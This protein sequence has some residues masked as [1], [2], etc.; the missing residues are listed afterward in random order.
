MPPLEISR[1]YLNLQQKAGNPALLFAVSRS[2]P[3]EANTTPNSLLIWHIVC[4][5][6]GVI[7][8]SLWSLLNFS[9]THGEKNA[10]PPPATFR[11]PGLA[12][13]FHGVVPLNTA[14]HKENTPPQ[15]A[16]ESKT[17]L[18]AYHYTPFLLRTDATPPL[19]FQSALFLCS[20]SAEI[21]I[22]LVSYV[23]N[24]LNPGLFSC[25]EKVNNRY[26]FYHLTG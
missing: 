8:S 5:F 15:L 6:R 1:F 12:I 21:W 17:P 20:L 11:R 16:Q 19:S 10:Y 18:K 13:R 3:P 14:V 9:P 7:G 24:F 26:V 25:A 23:Q 22:M 4:R 2:T